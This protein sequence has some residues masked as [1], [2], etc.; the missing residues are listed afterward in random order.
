MARTKEKLGLRELL[1]RVFPLLP[2]TL[3]SPVSCTTSADV[4]AV[5]SFTVF[6][7]LSLLFEAALT[8][9]FIWM[10]AEYDMDLRASENIKIK[11]ETCSSPIF[12]KEPCSPVLKMKHEDTKPSISAAKPG[13]SS[14]E[15]FFT[16]G[17]VKC[18]LD[19]SSYEEDK[20]MSYNMIETA[21]AE[22]NV[23]EEKYD[24]TLKNLPDDYKE[25]Y[26]GFV[27]EVEAMSSVP[28]LN[29]V[30]ED[31]IKNFKHFNERYYEDR[32]CIDFGVT[33]AGY[34]DTNIRVHTNKLLLVALASGNDIIRNDRRIVHI[35]FV[36][37]NNDRSKCEDDDKVYNVRAGVNGNILEINEYI[38][39]C[40]DLMRTDPKG[41]GFIAVLS[42]QGRP[43]RF[44]EIINRQDLLSQEEYI[45]YLVKRLPKKSV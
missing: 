34:C 29:S 6:S 17:S 44:E 16:D 38:K 13:P 4:S 11:M 2:F 22:N 10:T 8:L 15:N 26:D 28:A 20:K 21:S 43:E 40:P 37:N 14:I 7:S 9:P 12:K 36:I 18:T 45:S 35:N 3:S 33:E 1:I 42:P 32:Y 27:K 5:E 39:T 19:S 25:A 30:S 23:E 41:L 24:L 31:Y